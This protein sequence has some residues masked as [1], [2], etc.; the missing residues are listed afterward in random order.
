MADEDTFGQARF[1][2]KTAP[3]QSL[4]TERL[5]LPRTAA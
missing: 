4:V 2:A 3:P 5:H 1:A